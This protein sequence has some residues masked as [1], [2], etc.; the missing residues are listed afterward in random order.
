MTAK[1]IIVYP[2]VE[3]EYTNREGK[4]AVFKSKGLIVHNGRSSIYAEALQEEADEIE[5]FNLQVGE[6]VIVHLRCNVRNYTDS[7]GDN[8]VTN[9]IT[10]THLMRF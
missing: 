6:M 2:L 10:I 4:K 7:K 9:D 1:V 3:R 8:R 5:K